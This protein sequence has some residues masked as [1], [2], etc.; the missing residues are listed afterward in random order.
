MRRKQRASE[1]HN[2]GGGVKAAKKKIR[3]QLWTVE[4]EG[5]W[6]GKSTVTLPGTPHGF[7]STR[8]EDGEQRG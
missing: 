7:L 6:K 5:P 1:E 2:C 8:G 4:A 3:N